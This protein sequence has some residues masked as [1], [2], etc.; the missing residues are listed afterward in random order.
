MEVKE[1]FTSL[2]IQSQ[3]MSKIAFSFGAE[4]HSAAKVLAEKIDEYVNYL[5]NWQNTLA[6]EIEKQKKD[7]D[8][9]SS[10]SKADEIGRQMDEAA[11]KLMEEAAKTKTR[12]A[13]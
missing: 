5:D 9:I 12:D 13:S 2:R 1:I 8:I 10:A 7:V 3:Y 4:L 11:I 6:D